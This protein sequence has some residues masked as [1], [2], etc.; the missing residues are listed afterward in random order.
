MN[1]RQP[2]SIEELQLLRRLILAS[3]AG[4]EEFA[5]RLRRTA[6]F[7]QSLSPVQAEIVA[8]QALAIAAEPDNYGEEELLIV[9]REEIAAIPVDQRL[10]HV[11]RQ[12]ISIRN[13]YFPDA[14]DAPV[15]D[16]G[17]PQRAG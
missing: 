3:G 11:S 2:Y 17:D 9:A 14:P 6:D 1:D 4:V 5:A 7:L 8:A 15:D 12:V 16:G 10:K 13:R